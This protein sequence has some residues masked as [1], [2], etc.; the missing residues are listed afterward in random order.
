[1]FF[2]SLLGYC[3]QLVYALNKLLSSRDEVELVLGPREGGDVKAR[4]TQKTTAPA[5]GGPHNVT[6]R[7]RL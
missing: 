7:V 4:E 5:L 2:S 3:A 1:M 6:M